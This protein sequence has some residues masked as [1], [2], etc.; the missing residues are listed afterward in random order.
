M[1]VGA[2]YEF[3]VIALNPL[4]SNPSESVTL[5][6]GSL[7]SSPTTISKIDETSSAIQLYWADDATTIA[8]GILAY[9]FVEEVFNKALG[10]VQDQVVYYGSEGSIWM[11]DLVPGNT[12]RYKVKAINLVGESEFSVTYAFRVIGV[13]STPVNFK[14]D[15]YSDNLITLVWSQPLSTGGDVISKYNVYSRDLSNSVATWEKT[16]YLGSDTFIHEYSPAERH[17]KYAF[18]I[19]AEN[20]MYESDWSPTLIV[21]AISPPSGMSKPSGKDSLTSITVSW[22]APISDSSVTPNLYYE[23]DYYILMMKSEFSNTYTEVYRGLSTFHTLSGLRQGFFYLF[24]VKAGNDAGESALSVASDPIYAAKV[25]D[26]PVNLSVF[27]RSNTQIMIQWDAPNITG[28]MPLSEYSVYTAVGSGSFIP[29]KVTVS[30]M[31]YQLSTSVVSG[32][33]Y[34]FKVSAHNK[35]GE[36]TLSSQ[37]KVIAADLPQK[38]TSPPT[39]DKYTTTSVTITLPEINASLNGGSA[40]TGYMLMMDNGLGDADSFV[41]RSDSLQTS[42]TINGLTPGRTY[43][44]KYAG[45]NNVYDSD[46]LF[47]GDELLFSETSQF[48]TI[49]APGKPSN[50]RQS[51]RN[52][53]SSIAIE[54]DPP[55]STGGSPITGYVVT[56]IETDDSSA[57]SSTATTSGDVLSYII[58]NLVPGVDY[59]INI[60]A[61]TE[62]NY[63][64]E[65]SVP[66]IGTPGIV[67]IAPSDISFTYLASKRNSIQ[68]NW[69]QLENDADSGGTDSDPLIIKK[70]NLYMKRSDQTTY[71]LVD[72]VEPDTSN[73]DPISYTLDYLKTGVMYKFKISATNSIGESTLS[74][75]YEM[76]PGTAPSLPGKPSVT[77]V[78]PKEIHIAWTEPFDSGGTDIISYDIIVS[79]D[80]TEMY[81]ATVI[82]AQEYILEDN[83]I[84][85]ARIYTVKVRANNFITDMYELDSRVYSTETSFSTSVLPP[86]SPT[87]SASGDILRNTGTIE[88]TLLTTDAQRGFSTS[89]LIYILEGDEGRGKAYLVLETYTED[90]SDISNTVSSLAI[91]DK[92]PGIEYKYRMRVMNVVGYSK[93][94][95][96][97]IVVFGETPGMLDPPTFVDRNGGND[98]LGIL[99]FVTISWAEPSDTGG[100]PILGY[101]VLIK[102]TTGTEWIS[103][104]DG[105]SDPNTFKWKIEGQSY[106]GKSYYFI[107][108][109]R[110]QKGFPDLVDSTVSGYTGDI[111][112]IEVYFATLPSSLPESPS[113]VV[114]LDTLTATID[115]SWVTLDTNLNGGLEVTGYLVQINSGFDTD[116]LT[117]IEVDDTVT[118]KQYTGLIQGAQYKFR[119]AAINTIYEENLLGSTVN[120][121]PVLSVIAASAPEAVASLTQ[122]TDQLERGTVTMIWSAAEDNGSPITQYIAYKEYVN[123]KFFEIYRG[124]NLKFTDT[125]LS[126]S[127]QYKYKVVAV[128]AAGTSPDSAILTGKPGENPSVPLDL[129]VEILTVADPASYSPDT[130]QLTWL[131]PNDNGGRDIEQYSILI[132][133]PDDSTSLIETITAAAATV[134]G[135]TT[136]KYTLTVLQENI[137]F[138]YSFRV[139]AEND[140]GTGKYSEPV[141]VVAALIPEPPTLQLVSDVVANVESRQMTSLYL[142]FSPA[143]QDGGSCL[144]G[145]QL[146]RDEGISGTPFKMIADVE[147][148]QVLYNA[149]SLIPGRE[150]NFK[151]YS[152]NSVGLSEAV[153]MAWTI[154][155]VPDKANDPYLISSSI[156]TDATGAHITIGWDPLIT[157]P[158]L[159]ITNYMVYCDTD[160]TAG[161]EC[162][163]PLSPADLSTLEVTFTGLTDGAEYSFYVVAQNDIGDGEASNNVELAAASVPDQPSLPLFETSTNTSISIAWSPPAGNGGSAIIGYKVYMYDFRSI[164]AELVY[165]GTSAPSVLSL[166]QTG[167]VKS[168]EYAFYV[169]AINR[170]GESERSES[171]TFYCDYIPGVPG[172]PQLIS[173]STASVKFYWTPPPDAR[174]GAFDKYVIYRKLANEA[175]TEWTAI[176]TYNVDVNTH[177]D[178]TV[179]GDEDV[180]Y[181]IQARDSIRGSTSNVVGNYSPRSTFILASAPSAPNTPT[182]KA[183][184]RSSIT[185][186]WTPSIDGGSII[187]G[188]K[189]YRY[190]KAV[191]SN[192]LAY[193]GS[194]N[195]VIT[196]FVDSNLAAGITFGYRVVAINRVGTSSLSEEG[197]GMTGEI[198][199]KPTALTYASST[200]TSI[201][202]SFEPVPDNGG[203][204]VTKYYLYVVGQNAPISEN[205]VTQ[206]TSKDLQFVDVA[207]LTPRETYRFYYLAANQKGPGRTSDIVNF[208]I[209]SLPPA[210][211]DDVVA[212]N[213]KPTLV[214][215]KSTQTSLYITWEEYEDKLDSNDL[216]I[217]GYGLYMSEAGSDSDFVL[218]YDGFSQP[219]ILF[220]N[221]TNLTTGN[222]YAFYFVAKNING[223]SD[224]SDQDR[225]PV[226]LAPSVLNP[227]VFVE[228]TQ[229]C[230]ITLSWSAPQSNG[231]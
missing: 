190:N 69:E 150:Y 135:T 199:G 34:S 215:S 228:V 63:S 30:S 78:Y 122:D 160:E 153:D 70:Y 151:L 144:V 141:S 184:T 18:A 56:W 53:R 95:E 172:S 75:A 104:Y 222:S 207:S 179:S 115:L 214:E 68:I 103:V 55:S 126:P 8:N 44:A 57:T 36:G 145:Y 175:E 111:N 65:L 132:V 205:D 173:S 82:G 120:Y 231:G 29:T 10:E 159:P 209:G 211:S 200:D 183:T 79:L 96:V 136:L 114:T 41:V 119:V 21:K 149:T 182:I 93:Y 161:T 83:N 101:E 117:A 218:V 4:E 89:D 171:G 110:N 97:L 146:Y 170:V 39:I 42:L 178:T 128:N 40:I 87:L 134:S 49:V 203:L 77:V 99:P 196:S 188:Y 11:D 227:P 9:S 112:H 191:G 201:T 22:E 72:E 2:D 176:A 143:L 174:G 33:I 118:T 148:E 20:S 116:F 61:V 17:E 51:S 71:T 38:P 25:P 6:A 88:W 66:L 169:S 98:D 64:E 157:V 220:Y 156:A 202:L 147:V 154:G 60:V 108:Q 124:L 26:A 163:T 167:L 206:N 43:R 52:L 221:V 204:P 130:L 193:D 94:S 3:W 226:C 67:P 31:S 129:Q 14:V 185:V 139:A 109:A 62:L 165:D 164:D 219:D 13:P 15:S 133:D 197:A 127:S 137:G 177:L 102:E 1:E 142:L 194:S 50:L 24:K 35:L 59:S 158:G 121:S 46:N 192:E 187:T 208:A 168:R 216:D 74:T 86:N 28:G 210:P 100:L 123:D 223:Y 16:E 106:A 181:R 19:T 198:P 5:Q 85:P 180:Q 47:E 90:S 37:I 80:G 12:Y 162:D 76:M 155:V 131:E 186:S 48:T 230:D 113:A 84:I 152:Y 138:R 107:V 23:V 229:D 92:T 32:G 224:K 58:E 195:S 217:E 7:P 27:S 54:W 45:R 166:T 81:T 125:K 212:P 225:W 105:S 91:E 213:V 73:S 140:L 189:L